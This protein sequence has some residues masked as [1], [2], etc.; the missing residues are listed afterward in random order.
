MIILEWTAAI[1][2]TA[3]GMLAIGFLALVFTFILLFLWAAA[4]TVFGKLFLDPR[5]DDYPDCI[6]AYIK[7]KLGVKGSLI[8]WGC[9]FLFVTCWL[10]ASQ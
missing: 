9:W 7:W 6:A 1:V 2:Q 8:A 3:T 4:V 5:R 10:A